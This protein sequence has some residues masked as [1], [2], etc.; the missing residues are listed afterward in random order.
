MVGGACAAAAVVVVGAGIAAMAA[1]VAAA[2]LWVAICSFA[3]LRSFFRI[4]VWSCMELTRR[5]I[6][7]SGCSSKI[8]SIH[9]AAATTSSIV[10]WPSFCT[11]IARILSKA[12]KKAS[13]A[14]RS[15]ASSSVKVPAYTPPG[16]MSRLTRNVS[17]IPASLR[18]MMTGGGGPRYK[19]PA[20]PLSPSGVV[21]SSTG[22]DVGGRGVDTQYIPSATVQIG[23]AVRVFTKDSV[24]SGLLPL[25][26]YFESILDPVGSQ[27]SRRIGGSAR[28]PFIPTPPVRRSRPSAPT[29]LPPVDNSVAATAD[30][31]ND[32]DSGVPDFGI[33]PS[34]SSS[35]RTSNARVYGIVV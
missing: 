4:W 23:E 1:A 6:L 33:S 24:D 11:S 12:P 13:T 27:S 5:S 9:Q 19:V 25:V 26:D 31:G 8:F 28:S 2:A 34:N 21:T 29:V 15:A 18:R 32:N 7:E 14:C 22:M 20:G 16:G 30:T 3:S 10:R 17:R 35:M